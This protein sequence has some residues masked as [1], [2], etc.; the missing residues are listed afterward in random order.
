M[1]QACLIF[2][3]EIEI[4]TTGSSGNHISIAPRKFKCKTIQRF[5]KHRH[6]NHCYGFTVYTA[7]L[8]LSLVK[9]F[10][11][12]LKLWWVSQIKSSLFIHYIA[13]I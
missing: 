3:V 13:P 8:L 7:L 1:V 4:L 11:N 2:C 12:F 10:L 5:Y 9:L 6:C